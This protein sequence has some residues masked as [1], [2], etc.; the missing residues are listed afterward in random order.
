MEIQDRVNQL[1]LSREEGICRKMQ[2]EEH[3]FDQRF[4]N[5]G[6]QQHVT[7]LAG[8]TN[9]IQAGAQWI[10]HN[11]RDVSVYR[12]GE[13]LREEFSDGTPPV[14]YAREAIS[15]DSLSSSAHEFSI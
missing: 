5:L 14:D 6:I 1:Y 15:G 2:F 11:F 4:R 10:F 12:E 7:I 8:E 9:S 3:R 13:E